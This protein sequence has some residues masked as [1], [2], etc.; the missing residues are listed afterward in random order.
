MSI[1]TH[2][3]IRVLK[4]QPNLHVVLVSHTLH[5]VPCN[6]T[7][8]CL[9][10]RAKVLKYYWKILLNYSYAKC[11]LKS[12]RSSMALQH[13]QPPFKTMAVCC[14]EIGWDDYGQFGNHRTAVFLMPGNHQATMASWI[15]RGW[16][17]AMN[18][19]VWWW[20]L[21]PSGELTFCHGKSPCWM[22]SST[23]NGHV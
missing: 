4:M 1:C 12:Q 3:T 23:I 16:C 6:G 7:S 14:A 20:R 15:S 5:D 11:L 9:M 22:G 10:F 2:S 17:W 18:F 19:M 8:M 13:T 21:L